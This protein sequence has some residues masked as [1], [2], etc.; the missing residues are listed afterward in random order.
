LIVKSEEGLPLY[1]L[2]AL[3]WVA[4]VAFI[5]T[6]LFTTVK[7]A[8]W[9]AIPFFGVFLVAAWKF[10]GKLLS[11]VGA[12]VNFGTVR[13]AL[14]RAPVVGGELKGTVEF[15]SGA[16]ALAKFDAELVCTREI[17]KAHD[18]ATILKDEVYSETSEL[19]VR[20]EPGRRSAPF[21]IAIPAREN[22][23]GEAENYADEERVPTFSW[24]LRLTAPHGGGDLKRSF[25]LTVLPAGSRMEEVYGQE[26]QKPAAESAIALIVANLIPLVLVFFGLQSVGSLIVLYWAENLVIG[27]YTILRMLEAGRSGI[28]EKAGKTFFFTLHYGMFCMVHGIFVVT[29]FV[30]REFYAELNAIPP[31][32]GPLVFPHML[33]LG[34]KTMGLFSLS[35]LLLPLLALVVSHGV[36]FYTNYLRN[37]RYLKS[38]ADDSF[39]RPYPRMILLHLAIIGGG[40][41]IASQGQPAPFLAALVVGKTVIDLWLHRRS[42]RAG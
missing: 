20:V 3:A 31:W 36:S 27:L 7:E 40:F 25:A 23:S 32:P 29:M 28:V 22:P 15:E 5:L 26:A 16:A 35:G 19:S 18:D 39:W 4:F 37:G 1:A 6:G 24:E 10:G 34:A 11:S 8:P 9:V 13:L 2:G 42:N 38:R 33:W 17:T 41:F 30:P 12:Y 21:A 14:E